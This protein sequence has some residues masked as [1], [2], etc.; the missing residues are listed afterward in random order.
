[1]SFYFLFCR[2]G[3]VMK[4]TI[5]QWRWGVRDCQARELD[6]SIVG[7]SSGV[8]GCRGGLYCDLIGHIIH[9][10]WRKWL[11]VLF[12]SW[13]W[14]IG[15][16]DNAGGS[17]SSGGG[18][19]TKKTAAYGV[20]SFLSDTGCLVASSWALLFVYLVFILSFLF[21]PFNIFAFS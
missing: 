10:H 5:Y 21:F 17:T 3:G 2:G 18:S 16:R 9:V 7:R 8:I 13:W 6:G 20:A 11:G 15:N 12:L 19:G 1:M 14:D 4:I